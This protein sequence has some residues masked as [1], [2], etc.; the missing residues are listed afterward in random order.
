M[1][2]RSRGSLGPAR[3][4][5][6]HRVCA[7]LI[8]TSAAGC[9]GDR[10]GGA[11]RTGDSP[12]PTPA[13]AFASLEETLASGGP[14]AR[15]A[16]DVVAEGAV[17][18]EFTGALL[19]VGDGRE[20]V[21]ASGSFAGQQLDV[22]LISDGDQMFWTGSEVGVETPE[23]LRDALAIG[24]TRMG[25]LHNLARLSGAAPPDHGDGGVR[26]WVVVTQGDPDSIDVPGFDPAGALVLD[27]TV[28]GEPSGSFALEFDGP[29]PRIRHQVVQFP[30]GIMRVTERYRVVEIG[31]EF[32]AG[33]FD[34]TPLDISR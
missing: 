6:E 21:E 1:R 17:P 13:E 7:L 28:A 16:F 15:I 30:Q 22:T 34:T 23:A 32:P 8:A 12:A 5:L 25:I 18:A 24:L 9:G 14:P 4:R 31:A 11:E 2:T 29:L 27:I 20:R 33:A 26:E 10:S 19:L 3:Q